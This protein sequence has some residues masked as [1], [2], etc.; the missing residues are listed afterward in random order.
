MDGKRLAVFKRFVIDLATLSKCEDKHTAAIVTD[1]DGSQVY[2]IGVNGGPKGGVDCLCHGSTKY[3]CVHA[4]A[5][6]LAKCTSD[7]PDKVMI[8]SFSP[9]VTCASLMINCGIK[10]VYYVEAY[11]DATPLQ[12]LRDAGV[13]VMCI[14]DEADYERNFSRLVDQLTIHGHAAIH[15]TQKDLFNEETFAR[16]ETWAKEHGYEHSGYA[17]GSGEFYVIDW[18]ESNGS[19]GNPCFC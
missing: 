6:A 5:N 17:D 10:T 2:A 13:S 19:S 16:L 12:M 3:T 7:A 11:K 9:C 4:E 18:R 1:R 15:I 8:C 14:S